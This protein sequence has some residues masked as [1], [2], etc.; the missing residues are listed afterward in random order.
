M[1]YLSMVHPHRH[2]L[3]I[4]GSLIQLEVLTNDKDDTQ[5]K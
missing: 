4:H 1:N 5:Y 2:E 3:F